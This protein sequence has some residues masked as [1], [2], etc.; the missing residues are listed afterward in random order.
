MGFKQKRN[1]VRYA[2]WKGHSGHCVENGL[3]TVRVEAGSHS[4]DCVRCP[5]GRQQP[6][7]GWP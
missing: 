5:D 2:F 4:G 7:L 1:V 6:E 3:R